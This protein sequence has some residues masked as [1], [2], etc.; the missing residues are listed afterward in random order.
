MEQFLT[1]DFAA[2]SLAQAES[3][4]FPEVPFRL[5]VKGFVGSVNGVTL[6]APRGLGK[7][8]SWRPSELSAEV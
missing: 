2:E 1:F 3:L 8:H 6:S 4:I 5:P 7:V